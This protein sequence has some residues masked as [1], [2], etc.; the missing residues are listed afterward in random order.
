MTIGTILCPVDFSETSRHAFRYAAAL[1]KAYGARVIALHVAQSSVAMAG[2]FAGAGGGDDVATDFDQL[3]SRIREELL[4]PA[5]LGVPVTPDVTAGIPADAIAAYAESA[6]PDMIVIGTRGTS[7]LKHLV[8]GSVTEEVLRAAVCPVIAIPPGGE[9]ARH[10]PLRTVL[11]ATDFSAAS[12]AAMRAAARLTED[13]S[14]ELTVLHVNDGPADAEL[15]V[16]RPYDLPHHIEARDAHVR[17]SLE[18]IAARAFGGRRA[19][20]LRVATGRADHEIL[21]AAG[22][23]NA[24]LLVMGVRGRSA[25]NT[26]L[27][28]STTNSVVR[29]AARPVLTAHL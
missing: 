3:R 17:Q 18:Q 7:G 14:I 10:L 27:F 5:A 6:N 8:L 28:G 16:A 4:V 19:P 11:C 21:Q 13:P 12:L 9:A 2:A 26:L 29:R 15:F 24:D 1:A 20:K 23:I 22:E 25:V